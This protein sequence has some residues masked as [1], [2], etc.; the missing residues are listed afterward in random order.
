[1]LK[2]DHAQGEAWRAHGRQ[3]LGRTRR[4]RGRLSIFW[5]VG[6]VQSTP[7]GRWT[8]DIVRA[9]QRRKRPSP[10][11]V[12]P[13]RQGWSLPKQPSR[14]TRHCSGRR[15]RRPGNRDRQTK[16]AG[17]DS[18]VVQRLAI[19]KHCGEPF[20]LQPSAAPG[21]SRKRIAIFRG[22]LRPSF[23][24]SL[25]GTLRDEIGGSQRLIWIAYPCLSGG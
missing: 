13:M 20:R 9:M 11:Q 14:H 22:H 25:G 19:V 5:R 18:E 4:A 17:L 15:G 21:L 16:G 12:L 3:L 10:R 7:L 6:V 1:M 2:R 24:G 23:R 8:N